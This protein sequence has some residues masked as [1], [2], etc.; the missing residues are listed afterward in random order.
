MKYRILLISLVLL[1]YNLTASLPA[2]FTAKG[3]PELYKELKTKAEKNIDLLD[4]STRKEYNKLLRAHDDILMSYLIAY[5]E[6]AILQISQPTDVLS[7]YQQ[8]RELLENREFVY[9]PEFFLSYIAQQT[10]TDERIQAY[11]KAM[12][13]DGLGDI[14]RENTDEMELYREVCK[15]CLERLV[16]LPTSGRDQSPLD[17]SQKSFL[18]R[19]EEM[20]ILFVAA[21]RTVGLPA[22]PASA[23]W[24]AHIDNN[25]AWAEVWLEDA[26]HYTGDMDAA[27]Y[28]DQTWFSGLIDKTV[29]ILARGSIASESDEIL[30]T[31]H[32]QTVINSTPNYA[33]DRIRNLSILV[34]DDQG[35]PV[36]DAVLGIL[37]YN[38]GALRPLTF[39]TTN[40]NGVF[41]L[42]V[43]RGAFYVSAF[44]DGRHALK[45][46]PSGEEAD[47]SVILSLSSEDL[48]EQNEILDYPS[49][50]FDWKTAP[51]SWDDDVAAIRKRIEARDAFFA[52][53]AIPPIINATASDS[54]Y[55]SAASASRANYLEYMLFASRCKP[56]DESFLQY[57]LAGDPKDLWQMTADQ[58]EA[59]YGFFQSQK[60]DELSQEELQALISPGVYY[61]ELPQPWSGKR[62]TLLL[63]PKSFVHK[64]GSD[65]QRLRKANKWMNRRYRTKAGESL[66]GL[67]PL[68]IAANR[69]YLSPIQKRIMAVSLARAN[70]IPAGFTRLPNVI[71]VLID[72]E[73]EYWDIS[74]AEIWNGGGEEQ[75][76]NCFI[77][78]NI[79][80]ENELPL[81]IDASQL[82][83]TRWEDGM[84]YSLNYRF[85]KDA[86]GGYSLSIPKS[87][88]YLQMGYRISN[89]QTGFLMQTV[90]ASSDDEIYLTFNPRSYPRSWEDVHS[91]IAAIIEEQDLADYKIILI[92]SS[93][94]ENSVRVAE[95]LKSLNQ[96][97]LWLGYNQPEA[98]P[99]NYRY[100]PMWHQLVKEDQ[101]QGLRTLTLYKASSGWQMY[102]GMWENLPQ[103]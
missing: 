62:N 34:L 57:L 73:W 50:P 60:T 6:D 64:G 23:P 27:Y 43:G 26:W 71:S 16:F 28:P 37:V 68:H 103:D 72:G 3:N 84:F 100:A 90:D 75:S 13:A 44:K 102:E 88:Y 94:Q 52:L 29:L 83:M 74:K 61:E 36:S 48:A 30:N 85:E 18:G 77:K 67:I 20:Q 80:D 15:W 47:I 41:Y 86:Q 31:G 49:N 55:W 8:I 39:V 51:Q 4:K 89:D 79:F 35:D 38:W 69:K 95:K 40:E 10:V 91:A 101:R 92:G 9:S 19:C 42:S 2:S 59:L 33:K 45:S 53:R 54:L 56:V 76:G 1:V 87:K 70:S 63:Y 99:A 14:M 5:E 46:V 97:F 66:S 58:F 81:D 78:V 22:R 21:A 82:M 11:R 7:N 25:H 12:L 24:W 96:D 98:A 93:N 32:Y 17:I 65:L